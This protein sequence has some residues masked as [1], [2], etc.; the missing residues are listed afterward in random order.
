MG[1]SAGEVVIAE[2]ARRGGTTF[3]LAD[4]R[5]LASRSDPE[6]EA[7]RIAAAARVAPGSSVV[8]LSP[9]TP[10]LVRRL[11]KAV[12]ESGR[13]VVLEPRP[14]LVAAWKAEGLWGDWTNAVEWIVTDDPRSAAARLAEVATSDAR[15]VAGPAAFTT[16]P[17]G[18]E[19]LRTIG[20]EWETRRRTDRRFGALL[21][22]NRAANAEAVA[23]APNLEE[24]REKWKGRTVL[25]A[26]A[27]PSLDAAAAVLRARAAARASGAKG[28][29]LPVVA[30]GTAALPLA[31]RGVPPA[32]AV[33]TDPQPFAARQ[34]AEAAKAGFEGP[35]VFFPT[36]SPEAVAA[37]GAGK[38][39]RIRFAAPEG[40]DSDLVPLP[41]GGT[42]AT[43]AIGLALFLGAAE[44]LLAG[45]DLALAPE[46]GHARGTVYETGAQTNRFE[47]LENLLRREAPSAKRLRIP[48][49]G[50]GEVETRSPYP[51][52]LRAVERIVALHRNVRFVQTAPRGARIAGASFEPPDSAFARLTVAPALA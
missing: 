19:F 41:A 4:G 22:A 38:K 5:Y 49:A 14:A 34:V 43:T 2:K 45:V 27:G 36:A 52:Y 50:G 7:E 35:W 21:E 3:R 29:L 48:A 51:I 13:V 9:G 37:A 6:R 16:A 42:V 11:Q 33:L 28:G 17:P 40:E 12:G 8:V 23:R 26:G 47:T 46:G 44:V 24:W 10:A 18:W 15:V 30:V 1:D 32:V 25:V 39:R 31:L 20:E